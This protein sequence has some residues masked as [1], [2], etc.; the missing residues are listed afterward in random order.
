[1]SV[2]IV[3]LGAGISGL[4]TAWFLKKQLGSQATI[5]IIEKSSRAGGW[6]QTV[7]TDQFLFEQGPRSCRTRGA[8]KETLALIESLGLQDQVIIPHKSSKK[9]YIYN[10]KGLK[11]LP[12][13][14]GIPFSSLTRGWIK[15]F[16]NDWRAPK[17]EQ[18]DESIHSFF[19]RRLGKRWA[20]QLVDPFVLGIYAGD[21]KRLSMKSTFP[22]FYEWEKEEGS[23]LKGAWRYKKSSCLQSPFIETIQRS[24]LFSFKDGL[25][26]LP[27]SLA[28]ELEDSLL[29]HQEVTKITFCPSS[30]AIELETGNRI[31]AD[32]LISTLPTPTLGGLLSDYPLLESKLKSLSYASLV[33]V[34]LGFDSS[35]L[36]RKGFGYLVPTQMKQPVLGCVWDSSIFPQQKGSSRQ[37]RLTLMLGGTLFPEIQNYSEEQITQLSLDALKQH[38]RIDAYPDVIQ[39][40]KAPNAVP[41]F[42]VG[43]QKWKEECDEVLAT[44]SKRLILSGTAW[45]GVSINDCIANA[46]SLSE[47]MASRIEK[48]DHSSL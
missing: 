21:C 28:C 36:R 31:Q 44:F 47:K 2:Q 48:K 45:S 27:L 32:Y 6:I 16:W 29:L 43:F 34:N 10:Q 25:E 40:K 33:I 46:R 8:G 18:E 22:I 23:L 12:G 19:S 37:T 9:R 35:A 41:Q 24:P 30:I 1:M 15:A 39:V 4:A 7:H 3:I 26:T 17:S 38:L 5:Q 11:R 20:D 14:L 13:L 42:E